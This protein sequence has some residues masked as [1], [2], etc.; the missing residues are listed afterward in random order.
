M[1][2]VERLRKQSRL[3]NLLAEARSGVL[4][5]TPFADLM[6]ATR[7][8]LERVAMPVVG[9][10]GAFSAG[11]STL[12]NAFCGAKILPTGVTPTTHIPIQVRG[13][14]RWKCTVGTTEGEVAG[15][16]SRADLARLVATPGNARYLKLELPE[17]QSVPWAW[18]DMPGTN[19]DGALRL[20]Q[21]QAP[22]SLVDHAILMTSA[23][24]PMAMT[25]L[26]HALQLVEALPK[27][28]TVVV[29]RSDQLAPGSAQEVV[30]YVQRI[31]KAS[32]ED[33]TPHVVG[34]SSIGKPGTGDLARHLQST[35]C[36][37]QYERLRSELEGWRVQLVDLKKL[38]RMGDLASVKTETIDRL[39]PRLVATA[40][41]RLGDLKRR[42]PSASELVVARLSSALPTNRRALHNGAAQLLTSDLNE[43]LEALGR[44]LQAIVVRELEVNLG[45]GG[46]AERIVQ[47]ASTIWR[48][49]S[50]TYFAGGNAAVGAGFGLAL[51]ALA[52]TPAGLLVGGIVGG[53]LGGFLGDGDAVSDVS[54]MRSE[55]IRPIAQ[56][57]S[58]EI[59]RLAGILRSELENFCQLMVTAVST[60]QQ[61]H[62]KSGLIMVEKMIPG[63]TE[64][65]KKLAA[66][67]A[68]IRSS[69]IAMGIRK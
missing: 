4:A 66:D 45:G 10:T 34:Y 25:D 27:Q 38:L 3:A 44:E 47:H 67:L 29:S 16:S 68:E 6:R 8:D 9:V 50:P 58:A 40:L 5:D 32:V 59:D 30:S 57:L 46:A 12:I 24:Q 33:H 64:E 53:L 1:T 31:L 69:E 43:A 41:T 13:G 42:L 36:D 52:T 49:G 15:P 51:G 35:I 21:L 61:A 18:L 62:S 14:T 23:L 65:A 56:S 11:K 26:R 7:F 48:V 54:V 22:S 28:L 63:A 2:K 55:V 60:Y 19:V 39:K 17:A 37:L 20:T